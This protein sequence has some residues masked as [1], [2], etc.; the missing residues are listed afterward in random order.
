[1]SKVNRL[2][3][4]KKEGFN[5]ESLAMKND[6]ED[7]LNI[8]LQNIRVINRYDVEG[9]S[10]DSYKKV[11]ETILSEPN[12]DNIYYEEIPDVKSSRIF[13]IEYLPGQ[14]DQRADWA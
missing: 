7:S 2:F 9:I 14:Y 5:L 10:E 4:E 12:L 8:K 13:A 11:A 6:I 3:V 1:M